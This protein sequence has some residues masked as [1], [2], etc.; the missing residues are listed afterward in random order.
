MYYGLRADIFRCA[1][2]SWFQ[3]VS[4]WARDVFTASASTGLSDLFK[5]ENHLLERAKI[6]EVESSRT[7]KLPTPIIFW[8]GIL[9][10]YK[11][12]LVV[13]ILFVSSERRMWT[14]IAIGFSD[15]L[16]QGPAGEAAL[17]E[18]KNWIR[19]SEVETWWN[20]SRH[21]SFHNLGHNLY[22]CSSEVV[23]LCSPSPR[24]RG[25]SM[26]LSAK[27]VEPVV[28]MCDHPNPN[29]LTKSPKSS[30]EAWLMDK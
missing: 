13:R 4:N 17:A 30:E 16:D 24:C 11:R 20:K 3:V 15:T 19:R 9:P 2:I 22:C 6:W 26:L 27:W 29:Q 10:S 12:M 1:S 14:S 7:F 18:M 23:C 28:A 21:K 5:A 8:S 25:S